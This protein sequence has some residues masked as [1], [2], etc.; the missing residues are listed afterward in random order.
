MYHLSAKYYDHIYSFKDYQKESD[1][2]RSVIKQYQRSEGNQLL[3]VACGTGEHIRYLHQ[4]FKVEGLDLE[5]EFLEIARSKFPDLTFH[6]G[7]MRNF[8]LQQQFDVVICLF[9]AI[10]YMKTIEDLHLAIANMAKHLLPGGVL[11]VEPW[12]FPN[13]WRPNTPH[14]QTVN[15]PELK[16]ARMVTSMTEGRLAVMDMH[17][18][19]GTPEKTEHFVERHEMLLATKEELLHAVHTAGLEA[20]WDEEGLVGRGLAIG[21]KG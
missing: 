6:Q 21:V 8:D 18:V 4:D 9:S 11:I 15:D 10:G 13:D 3:D 17:H 7:D 1:N 16:I 19:V 14:M 20:G 2:L 12:I 5:P